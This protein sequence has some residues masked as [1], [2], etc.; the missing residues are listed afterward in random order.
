MAKQ[1]NARVMSSGAAAPG[2]PISPR[3]AGGEAKSASSKRVVAAEDRFNVLCPYQFQHKGEKKTGWTEVGAAFASKDGQGVNIELRPGIS[4]SG[5]LVLRPWSSTDGNS[6]EE[7][8]P[9]RFVYDGKAS[10]EDLV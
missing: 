3:Q 4:V 2:G 6:D 8:G 10:A 9:R 5:R 1:H 7:G